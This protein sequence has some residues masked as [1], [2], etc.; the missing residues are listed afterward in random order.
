MSNTKSE[1]GKLCGVG[2]DVTNCKYHGCDD[3]C[4]AN[5]ISV[6]SRDAIRKTET[7]CSTF[8]AKPTV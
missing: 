7:F 1:N 8:E 3:C 4:H 2:C 5:S 6:E